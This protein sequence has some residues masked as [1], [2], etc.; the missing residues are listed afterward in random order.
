MTE[1]QTFQQTARVEALRAAVT[2]SETGQVDDVLDD[3][4]VLYKWLVDG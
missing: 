1:I 4:R 2:L 3:A